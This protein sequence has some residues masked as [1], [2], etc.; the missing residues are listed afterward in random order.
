MELGSEEDR[1]PLAAVT[2]DKREQFKHSPT[3]ADRVPAENK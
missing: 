3:H 1:Q 2:A